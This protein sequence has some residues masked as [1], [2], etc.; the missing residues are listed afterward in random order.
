MNAVVRRFLTWCR[1]VDGTPSE[2]L[3][4][5]LFSLISILADLAFLCKRRRGL[6]PISAL[7]IA[8][9]P[10]PM[11]RL[12]FDDPPKLRKEFE[13]MLTYLPSRTSLPGKELRLGAH[14]DE[15][16][17]VTFDGTKRSSHPTTTCAIFLHGGG[18]VVGNAHSSDPELA[19][20]AARA[21]LEVYSVTYP[22]SPE[23]RFPEARNF[24]I[25]LLADRTFERYDRIILVGESAGGNLAVQVALEGGE[26]IAGL[27][28]IYPFL[29]LT[30][31]CDTHETFGR[32]LFMTTRSLNWF[33]NAYGSR[34]RSDPAVSPLFADISSL[35]QGLIVSAS[36]DPLL[37]EAEK[38]H[39]RWPNSRHLIEPGQI[40]GFLQMRGLV[41][42][43]KRSIAQ[44]ADFCRD[45]K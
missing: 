45:L 34:D 2:R 9:T 3:R 19:E 8:Q 28:L 20:L 7:T 26:R 24:V 42:A 1:N 43:R 16:L 30:L 33:A 40:H 27:V 32:G 17:V 18:F 29:D 41:S 11:D 4:D 38:F 31:S 23:R 10:E 14:L 36:H 22:L 39:A 12:S 5:G 35:P 6:H 44:I 25:S 37:G 13:E 21:A 15:A